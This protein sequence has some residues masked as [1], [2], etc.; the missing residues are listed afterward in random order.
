MLSKSYE[1]ELDHESGLFRS[2]VF[3]FGDNQQIALV[4]AKCSRL[5]I[6]PLIRIQYGCLFGHVMGHKGC[7]C[8]MQTDS[9]LRAISNRGHGLYIYFR[10]HEGFGVGLFGK[11]EQVAREVEDAEHFRELLDYT[12]GHGIKH[13]PLWIVP[14]I[15]AAMDI[16]LEVDLLTDD[17]GKANELEKHGLKILESFSVEI[18]ERQLSNF[19]LKERVLKARHR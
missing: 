16:P 1:F 11:A 14:S 7:D 13:A 9:S 10:D 5:E 2:C 15:L 12:E 3:S 17:N 19:G 6:R 18:D 4:A 8:R